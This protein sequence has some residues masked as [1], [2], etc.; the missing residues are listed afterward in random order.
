MITT[1][2]RTMAKLT[3]VQK[4]K[5]RPPANAGRNWV[6]IPH[7]DLVEETKK[8][9]DAFG[10]VVARTDYAMSKDKADLIASYHL[11]LPKVPGM[12]K[13]FVPSIAV[14]HSN[15][16]RWALSMFVGI[17]VMDSKSDK[18]FGVPFFNLPLA[19]RHT[20]GVELPVVLMNGVMEAEA[21][22]VEIPDVIKE[23]E[24]GVLDYQEKDHLTLKAG[25]EGVLPW[26]LIG[27]LD[28]LTWE[29]ADSDSWE[30]LRN[31]AEVTTNWNV[32]VEQL[33][34]VMKFGRMLPGY[35]VETEI[36]G[37]K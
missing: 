13:R 35:P 27:K 10:W 2:L 32:P 24:K 9:L 18:W 37:E 22:F 33:D 34:R 19:K 15:A 7:A 20:N 1:D 17:V 5:L 4:V 14:R 21:R 3:E 16:R 6:G 30:L 28:K 36:A 23:L 31:M 8:V 26:H 11:A 25:R 29:S 12:A